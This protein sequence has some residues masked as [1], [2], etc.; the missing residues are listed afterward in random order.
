MN[1][2][3]VALIAAVAAGAVSLAAANEGAPGVGLGASELMLQMGDRYKN[4]Y[5]AARLG[6]WDFARY[7]A[8]EIEE[9]IEKLIRAEPK[10]ERSAR[11][12]LAQT[13]PRLPE[14]IRTRD[15]QTFAAAFDEMR[16]ACE[17]CHR[18]NAHAYIELPIPKSAPSPVLNID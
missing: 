1:T 5:W 9:L 4:L 11:K 2:R 6:Q 12:F 15:W 13:Y 3:F 17:A 18:S 10:R 16:A 14:A 8:K 7:Q